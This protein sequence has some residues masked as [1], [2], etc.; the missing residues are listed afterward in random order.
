[1]NA[2]KSVT[3]A[4]NPVKSTLCRP[5]EYADM[6]KDG[7]VNITDALLAARYSVDLSV[8]S[9]VMEAA[10]INCDGNINILDALL[11]ARNSSGLF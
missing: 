10:D 1:M 6:D 7:L 9:F 5:I 4:F 2:A 11:I 3:A 8:D